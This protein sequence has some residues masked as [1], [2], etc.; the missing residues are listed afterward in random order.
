MALATGTS[1]GTMSILFPLILV[2]TWQAS[3]GDDIIFYSVSGQ[4]LKTIKNVG[5]PFSRTIDLTEY[6]GQTIFMN[7][8]QNDKLYTDQLVVR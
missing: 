3:G 7:I 8:I 6:S 1:W 5:V 4:V 2:P